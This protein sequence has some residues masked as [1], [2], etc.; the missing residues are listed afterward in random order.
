MEELIKQ[1]ASQQRKALLN[2]EVSAVELINEEYKRIENIDA[3]IGAFNSLCKEQALETAK[4]VDE[5]IAKGEALPPLAG[6]PLALK[7]NI[8]LKGTKTTASSKI[9]E[10]FVSPYDAT[11]S[12]KLK[13]NLIPVLGKVNLDEFAMGSSTENSAFKITR[14]PWDTNK[15]P[16]GRT[17]IRK[18]IKIRT[19]RFCFVSGSDRSI[20][21]M[22]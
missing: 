7:D 10:N 16:G 1:T 18:G 5:K 8:N 4:K 12:L 15:V 2:K 11:V 19:Y 17:D 6:I 14:N 3:Q 21:K 20:C 9:L 13:E 22:C